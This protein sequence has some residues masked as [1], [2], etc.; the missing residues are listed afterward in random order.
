MA[1]YFHNRYGL[2]DTQITKISA[3]NDLIDLEFRNGI[4]NLDSTNKETDLTKCC[5]ILIQI[6][7]PNID[8]CVEIIKIKK[9]K[10]HYISLAEL[11]EMMTHSVFEVEL[12]LYSNFNNAIMLIGYIAGH[13]IVFTIYESIDFR[14]SISR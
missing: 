7:D 12:D 4:Y 9:S 11:Q 10:L 1:M 6:S 3:T 14:I 13:K 5:H 2:H 8:N